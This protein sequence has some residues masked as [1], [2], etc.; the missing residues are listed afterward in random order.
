MCM[1]VFTCMY[2]GAP[3]TCL[4]LKEVGQ[5]GVSGPPELELQ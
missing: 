2:V 1:S 5:K 4:V 3:H